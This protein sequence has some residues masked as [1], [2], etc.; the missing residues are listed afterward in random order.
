[1]ILEAILDTIL[2]ILKKCFQK[3][4]KR[5]N[6]LNNSFLAAEEGLDRQKEALLDSKNLLNSLPDS[7]RSFPNFNDILGNRRTLKDLILQRETGMLETMRKAYIMSNR[8]A[9][10][11]FQ[12]FLS[13][14]C[15]LVTSAFKRWCDA[16]AADCLTGYEQAKSG[17]A[18]LITLDSS[19]NKLLPT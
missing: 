19:L 13:F 6:D 11:N 3:T 9:Y 18:T 17:A 10:I 5:Q 8:F 4:M 14:H 2:P 12:N 1:M 7:V 15:K 16:E